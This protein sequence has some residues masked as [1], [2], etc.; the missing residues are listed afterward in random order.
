MVQ[1]PI[2]TRLG[3]RLKAL[4]NCIPDNTTLLWDLCCDHGAV[5]RAVLE[6]RPDCEVIFNDIHK[7]IMARL[8]T[9]LQELEASNYQLNIGPAQ[10]IQLSDQPNQA[11]VL[12]GV[13]AEQCIEI[14]EQLFTTPAGRQAYLIVSPATKTYYVRKFLCQYGAHLLDEKVVIENK[15]GYEILCIQAES[16]SA[17]KMHS[18]DQFLF[19]GVWTDCVKQLTHLQKT[20]DYY[21]AQRNPDSETQFIC[22]GYENLLERLKGV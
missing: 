6:T 21:R 10:N 3:A 18:T 9:Q 19:G 20:L 17:V 5:G 1:N 15:R 16:S 4:T 22:S 11:I 7:D 12:A 14:L 2:K 8:G 13:G